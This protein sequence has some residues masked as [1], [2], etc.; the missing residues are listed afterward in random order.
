MEFFRKIFEKKIKI[1]NAGYSSIE[2]K[3]NQIVRKLIRLLNSGGKPTPINIEKNTIDHLKNNIL[4][5]G[6]AI[7][8]SEESKKFKF[9]SEKLNDPNWW[10]S[11][12]YNNIKVV[13][14]FSCYGYNAFYWSI[15]QFRKYDKILSVISYRKSLGL[16]L[17]YKEIES[18]ISNYFYNVRIQTLNTE[19]RKLYNEVIN[20]EKIEMT[21]KLK[22]EMERAHDNR[23]IHKRT[24]IELQLI[25]G[26][27]S[28][29]NSIVS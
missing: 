8:I 5:F 27:Q 24:I 4:L 25:L 9:L 20:N 15:L 14:L 6:H 11:N 3:D 16:T 29:V 26:F 23:E 12:L 13:Y 1:S 2:N 17:D 19:D 10:N 21:K 28:K 18:C 7:P 22:V